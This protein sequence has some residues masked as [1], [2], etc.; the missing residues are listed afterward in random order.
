M[1]EEK[2]KTAT[3]LIKNTFSPNVSLQ[4]II[5][6]KVSKSGTRNAHLITEFFNI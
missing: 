2:R 4:G 6:D 1:S 3:T 5:I